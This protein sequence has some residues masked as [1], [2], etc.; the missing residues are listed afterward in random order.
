MY[1]F[2][3]VPWSPPY[4]NRD[5]ITHQTRTKQRE[6]EKQ[7]FNGEMDLGGDIRYAILRRRWRQRKRNSD[8]MRKNTLVQG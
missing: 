6:K 7:R 2:H 8:T 4:D 3:A 1:A 5:K